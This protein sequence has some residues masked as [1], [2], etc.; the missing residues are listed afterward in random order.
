[1]ERIVSATEARIRFGELM[2]LAVESQE[3]VVVERGGK[4][5]VVVLSIAEYERLRTAQEREEWRE[6]LKRVI[7]VGA[8]IKD[9]RGSQPLT[10][11]EEVIRQVREERNASSANLR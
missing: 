1:M 10:P 6:G 7:Q 3:P 5:C 8:R 4:P 2:Q 9:R 11:P